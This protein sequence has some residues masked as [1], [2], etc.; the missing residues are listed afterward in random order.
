MRR[1]RLNLNKL[2]I[3]KTDQSLPPINCSKAHVHNVAS[4]RT[5]DRKDTDCLMITE[6]EI[7][8]NKSQIERQRKRALELNKNFKTLSLVLFSFNITKENTRLREKK[9][10]LGKELNEVESELEALQK[11][12]NALHK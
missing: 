4:R 6:K 10:K 11:E 1:Y 3:K 9:E 7:L 8:P 12:L 5:S 2:G